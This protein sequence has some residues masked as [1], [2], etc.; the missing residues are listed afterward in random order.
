MTVDRESA[1][2]SLAA[3]EQAEQRTAQA[4][5]YGTAGAFLILWGLV[6]AAGYLLGQAYPHRA[7]IVWPVLT[8]AGFTVTL[9]MVARTRRARTPT[10][11]ALGWHLIYAQIAL[12]GFGELVVMTL[13]PFWFSCLAMSSPAS[14]SGDFSS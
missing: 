10:Q 2:T 3:I 1:A 9:A 7:G 8:I 11:K 14:G 13:G 12:I 6:T 4:I 5:L